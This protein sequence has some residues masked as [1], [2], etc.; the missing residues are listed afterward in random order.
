M[1]YTNNVYLNLFMDSHLPKLCST[2]GER[3]RERVFNSLKPS[4]TSTI[5]HPEK[6]KKKILYTP[7]KRIFLPISPSYILHIQKVEYIE[8][9]TFTL[10]EF[11]Q[12]SIL[13]ESNAYR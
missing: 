12:N 1:F 4:I 9:K 7:I 5:L 10:Q 2:I 3:E 8:P 11:K 6:K 13:E